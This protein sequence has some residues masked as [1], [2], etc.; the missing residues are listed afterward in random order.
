MK[1]TLIMGRC[2][3]MFTVHKYIHAETEYVYGCDEDTY[4]SMQMLKRPR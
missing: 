1:Q 3:G 4:F 2:I